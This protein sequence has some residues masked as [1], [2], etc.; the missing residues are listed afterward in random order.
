MFA[1]SPHVTGV[2]PEPAVLSASDRCD[3]C[4][5]QA[6]VE[7]SLATGPLLFCAHHYQEFEARLR[8][9][10]VAVRDERERLHAVS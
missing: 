8:A 3:R 6:Y 7:V 2:L 10:A 1:A 4:G 5:S 9:V